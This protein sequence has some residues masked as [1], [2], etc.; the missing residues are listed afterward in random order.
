[1]KR[2][3]KKRPIELPISS[4]GTRKKVWVCTG[5]DSIDLVVRAH[6]AGHIAINHAA[7]ERRLKGVIQILL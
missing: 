6:H 5:G 7:L 4:D 1:M 3:N 2:R